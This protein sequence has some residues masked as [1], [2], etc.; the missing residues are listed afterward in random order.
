MQGRAAAYAARLATLRA[1]ASTAEPG[2][3]RGDRNVAE[4]IVRVGPS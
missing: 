2:F 4:A 3:V 1:G